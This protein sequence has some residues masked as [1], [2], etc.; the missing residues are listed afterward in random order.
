MTE[1]ECVKRIKD[2]T[3]LGDIYITLINGPSS[4]YHSC[5]ML[6]ELLKKTNFEISRLEELLYNGELEDSETGDKI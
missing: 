3:K 5:S 6:K 1:L 4:I 2:L